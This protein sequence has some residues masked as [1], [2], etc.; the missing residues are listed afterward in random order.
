MTRRLDDVLVPDDRRAAVLVLHGGQQ[1]SM[2]PVRDRNASWW[3]MAIMARALK[4]FARTERLSLHLLQYEVRGW[5]DPQAPSPVTDARWALEQV[6]AT[7]DGPVVLV[8]HSMGGRTA[9]HVADDPAVLGV[10]GL[11]PWLPPGEPNRALEDRALHVLHGTRDR[12][13][14]APASKAYVERCRPI[15][16]EVSWQSLPGA[17]HFMFRSVPTWNGF[18]EDSVR[19][20]LAL[21]T[22]GEV[23][24][25]RSSEGP[26]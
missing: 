2:Q 23:R 16:T 1:S 15:A 13:T 10:V 11:A 9:C 26:V 5:N 8:G 17:G 4:G 18:V 14:S 24:G 12:W 6:R 21:G 22:D 3:R 25:T 19:R 20:I 7:F